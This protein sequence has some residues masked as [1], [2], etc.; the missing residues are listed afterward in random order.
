MEAKS[1][2][3]AG[4]ASAGWLKPSFLVLKGYLANMLWL[5]NG[6]IWLKKYF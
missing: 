3:G 4:M 5:K 1:I 2:K 6:L